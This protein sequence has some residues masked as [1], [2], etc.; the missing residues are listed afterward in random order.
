MDLLDIIE[1]EAELALLAKVLMETGLSEVLH[2]DVFTLDVHELS[3]GVVWCT[4]LSIR[5]A[6]LLLETLFTHRTCPGDKARRESDV[7]LQLVSIV[8]KLLQEVKGT[9]VV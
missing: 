5:Q 9:H 2:Q 8:V 1:P 6:L 7:S 3:A 4:V